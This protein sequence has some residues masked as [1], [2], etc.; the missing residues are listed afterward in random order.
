[1]NN[2]QRY[3]FRKADKLKS[4]KT[5]QAIFAEGKSFVQYPL[6]LTWL[7]AKSASHLQAGVGASSRNFKKAVDRNRIKRL[8]RE[9]WRLQKNEL[10]E[11]L[12]HNGK[13]LSV[14]IIYV[15]KELPLYEFIYEK[16]GAAIKRMRSV[17][18]E[19]T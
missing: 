1:M 5:I 17:I 15:G 14:F 4:R 18:N 13:Q 11:E 9:A 3:F 6:K 2:E 10:Q 19:N 12:Q 7:Q 8:M 16:M